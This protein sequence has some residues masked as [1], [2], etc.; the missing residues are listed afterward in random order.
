MAFFNIT[1]KNVKFTII[2]TQNDCLNEDDCLV[3][4]QVNRS[5]LESILRNLSMSNDSTFDGDITLT[6]REKQVLKYICSGRNNSQIAKRLNVSVHTAKLHVHN[7]FNKLS[8]QDRTEA[9]VKAIRYR[10]IEL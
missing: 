8:V 3:E 4:I 10:L 9:A 6:K 5:F 7:I 2:D 1:S